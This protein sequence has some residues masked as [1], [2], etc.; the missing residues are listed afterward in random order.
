[1]F[2]PHPG[3]LLLALRSEAVPG[4]REQGS[5]RGRFLERLLRRPRARADRSRLG[6]GP[7]PDRRLPAGDTFAAPRPAGRSHKKWAPTLAGSGRSPRRHRAGG[8]FGP[9]RN[10]RRPVRLAGRLLESLGHEVESPTRP[11]FAEPE[12]Q[13]HFLVVVATAVAVALTEWSQLLGRQ[14][15]A[16][17]YEPA[18][19]LLAALGRS[20]TVP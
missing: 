19:S 15:S 20:T 5:G 18:N 11:R 10:A 3:E 13:R 2:D 8:F 9:I 7:G 14:V 17:E 12:F 6:S 1:V 16:E 4:P